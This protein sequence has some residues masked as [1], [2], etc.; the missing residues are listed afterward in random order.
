MELNELAN[1]LLEMPTLIAQAEAAVARIECEIKREVERLDATEAVILSARDN[2][3]RNEAERKVNQAV[4]L[5][6]S[7]QYMDVVH[8]LDRWRRELGA[9]KVEADQQRNR[10]YA[11]RAVAELMGA[12]M[13]GDRSLVSNGRRLA[14]GECGL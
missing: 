13:L 9:A 7:P 14:I 2:W 12:Q 5:R 1:A 4:A 3:G 10:F 8:S 11:Y 6:N